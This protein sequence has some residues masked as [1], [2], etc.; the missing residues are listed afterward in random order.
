MRNKIFSVWIAALLL[1]CAVLGLRFPARAQAEVQALF[2]NVGKADAAVFWL[3]DARYLVDTGHKDSY[4]QLRRVLDAYGIDDLDG[5]IITH[6]DKDHR[7][8]LKKLLKDGLT[9][10]RLYAGTL[11]SEEDPA[12]HP[13]LEAS[14]KYGVP[15]SW[16]S[17]GDRVE[18]AEGCAF[19]VLGPL[20]RDAENENNNSLVLR[21]VTPDGDWLLTGDMETEEEAELI[22]AGLIQQA[23]ILKVAHHGEDDSTGKS[24]ALLARPQLA[25][26]STNTAAEPDTPDP[27]IVSRLEAVGS[28]VAVTQD[29]EVGILVTLENGSV[30]AQRVDWQ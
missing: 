19:E 26:I 15:L 24:F 3:G 17:A 29:A 2:V 5:I 23:D 12:E 22:Q 8:G 7:G 14:E 30:T 20:S 13:V 6:T 10:G 25:V 1:V 4:E 27:K 11:H 16:L 21:L 18:A 28:V 9:A